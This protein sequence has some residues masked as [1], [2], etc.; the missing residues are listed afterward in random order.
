MLRLVSAVAVLSLAGV[1]IAAS[2]KTFVFSHAFETTG[3]GSSSTSGTPRGLAV[4][5]GDLLISDALDDQIFRVDPSQPSPNELDRWGTDPFSCAPTAVPLDCTPSQDFARVIWDLAWDEQSIWAI[6]K[7]SSA[8]SSTWLIELDANGN[9]LRRVNANTSGASP[10]G[11]AFDVR[12]DGG[13][14]GLV[15]T[16]VGSD[17]VNHFDLDGNLLGISAIGFQSGAPTGITHFGDDLFLVSDAGADTI[18]EF[19]LFA[20]GGNATYVGQSVFQG[21]DIS[22]LTAI[23]SIDYDPVTQMLYVLDTP[24]TSVSNVYAFALIPEPGTGL[25]LASGLVALG[26]RRRKA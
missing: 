10:G 18:Y 9:M 20:D 8:G 19:R 17:F 13:A 15:S 3:Y 23:E 14:G 5:D 4:R 22:T 16:D 7:D 2:A 1:P 24:S 11:L 12:G 26:A 21:I 25:L 6:D